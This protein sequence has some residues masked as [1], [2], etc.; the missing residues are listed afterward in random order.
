[1]MVEEVFFTLD[2][3]RKLVFVFVFV[4]VLVFVI[5]FVFVSVFYSGQIFFTQ[6]PPVVPVPNMRY[7]WYFV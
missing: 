3:M 1:M 7:D 2:T 5:V 6:A 4:F